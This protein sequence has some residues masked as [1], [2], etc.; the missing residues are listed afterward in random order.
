MVSRPGKKYWIT[1]PVRDDV[2]KVREIRIGF[3]NVLIGLH[4]LATGLHGHGKAPFFIKAWRIIS[5]PMAL[6][7]LCVLVI[8]IHFWLVRSFRKKRSWIIA[9]AFASIPFILFTFIWLVG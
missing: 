5:F 4:P 8:T 3:W 9:G 2:Y 1:V 6:V 7:L